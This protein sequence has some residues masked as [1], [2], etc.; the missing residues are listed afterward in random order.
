LGDLGS[1]RRK[2]GS[3][4]KARRP[5]VYPKQTIIVNAA[6]DSKQI[7]PQRTIGSRVR[8]SQYSVLVS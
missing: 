4:G 8:P 5:N 6:L 7:R 3:T 2:K 1:G